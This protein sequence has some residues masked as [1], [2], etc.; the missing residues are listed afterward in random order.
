M[1][2]RVSTDRGDMTH[3]ASGVIALEQWNGLDHVHLLVDR[4]GGRAL[5]L[6]VWVDEEAMRASEAGANE[7]RERVTG[8]AEVTTESVEHFELV[9]TVRGPASRGLVPPEAIGP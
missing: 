8:L 9:R 3:F 5:A 6:S 4:E 7:M 2:A 1:H